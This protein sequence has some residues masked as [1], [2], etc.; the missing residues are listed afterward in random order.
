M[1]VTLLAQG[2]IRQLDRRTFEL[3]EVYKAA[4]DSQLLQMGKTSNLELFLGAGLKFFKSNNFKIGMKILFI[5]AT[6]DEEFETTI[7]LLKTTF[8]S[9]GIPYDHHVL[10][11]SGNQKLSFYDKAGNPKYYAIVLSTNDLAYKKENGEF[12]SALDLDQR[13]LLEQYMANHGVRMVSLYSYP[14]ARIGV[15]PVR[16]HK[17]TMNNTIVTTDFLRTFD[18][19]TKR[20]LQFPISKQWHYAAVKAKTPIAVKPF[21]V[22]KN[23]SLAAS[24]NTFPDGREEMHFYFTQSKYTKASLVLSSAWINWLTKGIYQGK[25]R[26]YLNTQVNDFLMSTNLWHATLNRTISDGS[27]AYRTTVADLNHL[28]TWQKSSL[29]KSTLNPNFKI[30]LSFNGQELLKNET[31]S[32]D[33]LFLRAKA[34]KDEFHWVA[35][36][37]AHASQTASTI[38]WEQEATRAINQE[39]F[40]DIEYPTLSNN[41][42]TNANV[43]AHFNSEALN[44]LGE[45]QISNMIG[46]QDAEESQDGLFVF[47][48]KPTVVY[49]NVSFPSQLTSEYNFFYRSHFKKT[50]LFS[51]IMKR[52]VERVSL[53]FYNYNILPY[54]F[55]QASLRSYVISN[56]RNSLFSFWTKAVLA[57]LRKH[58]TLPILSL[59]SD[60]IAQELKFKKDLET[61]DVK[62]TLQVFEGKFI[63]VLI[64]NPNECRVTLTTTAYN[65]VDQQVEVYSSDKTLET[66]ESQLAFGL[67]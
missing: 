56:V 15:S 4:Q 57:E 18:P 30:E 17:P 19:S 64:D 46:S 22:Y 9:Y 29:R 59:K 50:S 58:H 31:L 1:P 48:P 40:G 13:N 28:S 20:Y 11:E 14:N 67:K 52:E 47:T 8:H 49:Y 6:G 16:A 5:S 65:F 12:A 10:T 35:Q 41:S 24:V 38:K 39:L 32:K 42:V 21:L 33:A 66:T 63:E 55:H 60:A 37:F 26:V 62:T 51:E 27:L 23:V 45:Y 3:M 43:A 54:S 36:T 53:D 61:C 34:L 7:S 44:A 25:R 2:K